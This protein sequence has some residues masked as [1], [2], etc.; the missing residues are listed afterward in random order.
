MCFISAASFA[1]A[2]SVATISQLQSL[3]CSPCPTPCTHR[4]SRLQPVL[5]IHQG[6]RFSRSATKPAGRPSEAPA[7]CGQSLLFH[8]QRARRCASDCV[9]KL[10]VVLDPILGR[11]VHP[12]Q[13]ASRTSTNLYLC[14]RF[15][16]LKDRDSQPWSASFV[17][18]S[19]CRSDVV[20][21]DCDRH[22]IK[23]DRN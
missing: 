10:I 13:S 21:I 15:A 9:Q 23:L 22:W 2:G 17:G 5:G 8:K 3:S 16:Q 19:F 12:R 11:G 14:P 20:C 18:M 4:C 7:P 1:F 6:V